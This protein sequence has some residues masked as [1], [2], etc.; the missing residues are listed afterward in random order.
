M[1]KSKDCVE[2]NEQR[3]RRR[4][5]Q[6]TYNKAHGITPETIRKNIAKG[7]ED[8]RESATVLPLGQDEELFITQE[9]INELESEMLEAAERLE[10][11]RA[12]IIRDKIEE[13]RK[14]IGKSASAK[15]FDFGK[16]RRHKRSQSP[17][18]KQG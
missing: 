17:K 15:M 9:Y 12:A 10:F 4:K 11:E 13:M 6:E 5:K 18:R 1:T 14:H 2:R 3:N 8:Q 16:K 7:I